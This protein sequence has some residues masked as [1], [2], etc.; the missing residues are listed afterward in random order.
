MELAFLQYQYKVEKDEELEQ[1]IQTDAT[2]AVRGVKDYFTY[3]AFKKLQKLLTKRCT[4]IKSI[5]DAYKIIQP[6]LYVKN[7]KFTSHPDGG[8]YF[9]FTQPLPPLG[10]HNILYKNHAV[11]SG[12]GRGE[13]ILRN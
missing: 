1:E 12:G 5:K 8:N 2:E 13:Q 9:S 3:Q 7:E 4:D 10:L 6:S 11:I